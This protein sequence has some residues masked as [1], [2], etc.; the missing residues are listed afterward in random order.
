[1][2]FPHQKMSGTPVLGWLLG[3]QKTCQREHCLWSQKIASI[4]MEPSAP[5]GIKVPEFQVSKSHA[6][7]TYNKPKQCI[8]IKDKGSANG[9]ISQLEAMKR[10]RRRENCLILRGGWN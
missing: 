1:M 4:E 9:N 6:S 10:G 2:A 8:S 3:H 5:H 7:I